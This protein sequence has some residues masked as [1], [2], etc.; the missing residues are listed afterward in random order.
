MDKK[1][2][3]MHDALYMVTLPCGSIR[4]IDKACLDYLD[5]TDAFADLNKGQGDASVNS[6]EDLHT[7]ANPVSRWQD[8][9]PPEWQQ[10]ALKTIDQVCKDQQTASFEFDKGK[11]GKS[12]VTIKPLCDAQSNVIA[13]SWYGKPLAVQNHFK[14]VFDTSVVAQW[15]VRLEPL[16]EL[17]SRAGVHNAK[18]LE[19]ALHRPDFVKSLDSAL[20]IS[21]VNP[22]ALKLLQADD[23]DEF[24]SK[25]SGLISLESRKQIL[26][27]IVEG[28]VNQKS[29]F[30]AVN[31]QVNI[32]GRGEGGAAQLWLSFEIPQLPDQA[33]SNA[34]F[35]S[36]MDISALKYAEQQL[37]ERERFLGAVLKATPDYLI[38]VDVKT[39][40]PIFSNR[41]LAEGLGFDHIPDNT[42]FTE[43]GQY[44]HEDDHFSPAMISSIFERLSAGNIFETSLRLKDAMG[45][46][47]QLY[48]RCAGMEKDADGNLLNVVVMARDVTDVLAAEQLVS[49]NQRQFQLLADNFNDV[50]IATDCGLNVSFVSPSIKNVLGY[51]EENFVDPESGTALEKIGLK[52]KVAFLERVLSD[53][54]LRIIEQDFSEVLEVELNTA[55]SKSIQAEIKLS[56]LRDSNDK[57]EGMLFVLRDVTQR[58]RYEHDRLLASKVFETSTDGIYITDS[59]GYIEQVNSSFCQITG[60]KKSEIIGQKPSVLGSGWH[61]GNFESDIMPV[62]RSSGSWQGEIMSR[63][64]GGEAFLAELTISSVQNYHGEIS[65]FITSFKDITE[66]KNSQEHVKKLAYYDPLTELPNRMLFQDRLYQALQRGVRNRHFVAVLFLDLDGFKPVND[67]YGHAF[68]DLLLKQVSMRLA[69]CVRGDDTVARLG[70]DEFAIIL[71]SLKD[72]NTAES[73]AAKIS[74]K[75]LNEIAKSYQIR[76]EII[77][78]GTSIGISLYPDDSIEQDALLRYADIAMYHAKKSGKNQYQFFKHDM[79]SR[80]TKRQEL[81]TDLE[82]ALENDEFVLALQPKFQKN[83]LKLIGFEAL[84]RWQHPDGRL[85]KPASFIR[86]VAE[87]GLGQLLGELVFK[88]AVN[89]L[90]QMAE[91]GYEGSLSVNVFARHFRDGHLPRFIECLLKNTQFK[92]EQLMLELS[93]SMLMEDPGFTYSC[94]SGLKALGVQIALDDFATGELALQNLRRLPVDEIKL[95]RQFIMKIDED[96][97]QLQFVKTLINLAKGFDKKVCV[98]GIERDMQLTLLNETAVDHVQGYLMSEPLLNDE[99]DQFMQHRRAVSDII[100]SNK[101]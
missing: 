33:R 88:K 3:S 41:S 30:F 46:W 21:D 15:V 69:D 61:E 101:H 71:H 76:N 86:S 10:S 73:T 39:Q 28:R 47:R 22:Q 63:R 19:V 38:V 79:H 67:R 81:A 7:L 84:L 27:S 13:L 85:L 52:D 40:K 70:G 2:L 24:E 68:G 4:Y 44:L 9:F 31:E 97:S 43:I 93:E 62:L 100:Q 35:F 23:S 75:I 26:L 48:F 54:A 89:T 12:L 92:P 16:R 82:R 14:S 53:A 91:Q 32:D 96:P 56:V 20:L 64:K 37:E 60:Y 77:R 50:V 65:G 95:D 80:D 94:L 25:L 18:Q 42:P 98:E 87:L 83:D 66:A 34:I 49:E 29:D 6:P 59:D 8:L 90:S 58:K 57:L 45:Q 55:E 99:V 72:R 74:K 36:A 5:L 1:Q 17:L 78:I 11:L 51:T